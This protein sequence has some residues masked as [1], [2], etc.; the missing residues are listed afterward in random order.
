MECAVVPAIMHVIIV[1]SFHFAVSPLTPSL[2]DKD[3][4]LVFD[5]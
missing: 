3:K 5:A 1:L 4:E 2:V